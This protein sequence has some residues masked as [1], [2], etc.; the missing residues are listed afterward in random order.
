MV[1]RDK[2]GNEITDRLEILNRWTKYIEQL[3]ETGNRPDDLAIEE[4]AAIT[5]DEK[6]FSILR[7]VVL[8]LR[9]MKNGKA[10]GVDGIPTELVKCFGE[11]TKE[12]LSLCNK[13]YEKGEW[14]EDFTETVL[15]PIPKKNNVRKCNDFRTITLISHSARFF[16]KYS[17]DVYILRWKNSCKKSSF[18][19]GREKVQE[20][21]LDCYKRSAKGKNKE[22]YIAFVDLKK[23]SDRVDWNKQMGIL[24]K[25]DVD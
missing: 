7:E 10:T 15:L 24:K 20:M 5:E 25:I 9:K 4:E 22:V 14:P 13:I 1:D 2:I 21:Q 6:G 19:S 18:A 3:Y 12:I 8:A 16:C 17:I 23:A 11:D